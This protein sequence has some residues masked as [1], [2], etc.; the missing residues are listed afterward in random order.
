[1]IPVGNILFVLY[2]F[3][4]F[5]ERSINAGEERKIA[6]R[7][8]QSPP[9]NCGHNEMGHLF[10]TKI[11]LTLCCTVVKAMPQGSIHPSS[12]NTGT[13]ATNLCVSV[14]TDRGVGVST[15]S[16]TLEWF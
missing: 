10:L 14:V 7:A 6:R 2:L 13:S 16:L 12:P 15:S 8:F 4:N 1:M 3:Q 9:F 5:D 11:E